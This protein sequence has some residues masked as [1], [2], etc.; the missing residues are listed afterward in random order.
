M[1]VVI[2]H[3]TDVLAVADPVVAAAI[4]HIR[5]SAHL[6]LGVEE[7]ARSV[8]VGRRKLERLFQQAV[9]WSPHVEILRARMALA[10][11]LLTE[12]DQ[13]VYAIAEASGFAEL[14]SFNSAFRRQVRMTPREWRARHSIGGT[15]AGVCRK[16]AR[17]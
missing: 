7:V 8:G 4:R 17:F 1:R 11:Q 3:S 2:R 16:S 12:T 13:P 5:A 10:K 14:R 15:G 6:P 9:G